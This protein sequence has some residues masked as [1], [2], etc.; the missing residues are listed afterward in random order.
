VAGEHLDDT[1]LHNLM[2]NS[3]VTAEAVGLAF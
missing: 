3:A 2:G 1:P